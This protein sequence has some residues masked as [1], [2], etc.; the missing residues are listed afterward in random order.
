VRAIFAAAVRDR[1]IVRTPAERIVLPELPRRQI[2]P[3]TPEQVHALIDAMPDRYRAVVVVAAGAGLRRGELF[4]LQVGDIDFLR[5]TIA[6]ERQVVLVNNRPQVGPLKT[7]PSYRTIPVGHVVIDALAAHLAAFPAGP[8]GFV[9]TRPA[10]GP[11]SPP[12]FNEAAWR[13]ARRVAGVPDVSLHDLRHF[14]ASALI[15]AGLSVK[16]VSARLGHG[17]AAETLNTYS[18]LWPDDEDRTRQAI[19]D[20]LR[21]DVLLCAPKAWQSESLRRSAAI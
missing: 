5:H 17:N 4:G 18:H 15:R 10:G 13:S 8:E 7:R 14:Y 3:L 9:F 20:V 21:R 16:A 1:L 19:D 6:V 2:V 12:R 11:W